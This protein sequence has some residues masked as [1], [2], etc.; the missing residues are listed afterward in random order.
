M[1]SCWRRARVGF[2]LVVACAWPALA[3]AQGAGDLD[4]A[5]AAAERREFGTALALYERLLDLE[6]D[7]ADLWIEAARVSGYADRNAEAAA[8]YRRALEIAPARRTDLLLS[9]AWQTLWA[10]DAAAA[11]SLFDE[12][13]CT[14]A[15]RAEAFDGL[16]QARDALDD[17]EGSIAAWRASLVL[18]PAQ[19]PVE[20][21]LARALMWQGRHG[22]ADA[23]LANA[24][25]RDD[26]DRGTAWL[27][28]QGWNLAG[29]HHDATLEFERLGGPTN[30]DERLDVARAWA[31]SGFDERA[32]AL[33]ADTDDQEAR[34][35][36][37]YRVRR[38]TRPFAD[39]SFERSTDA[40]DLDTTNAIAGFGWRP[41][42]GA[43]AG[44][45][46]RRVE[47]ESPD[48]RA[49]GRELRASWRQ[50]FGEPGGAGG[51]WWPSFA[52]RASQWDG[53]SPWTGDARIA[54]VPRDGWRIDAEAARALVET[55]KAIAERVTVDVLSL[56]VDH[57]PDPR[58]SLALALAAFRFDDG[59]RRERVYGRA[60]WR[61]PVTVRWR[62]GVE[63]MAF[64]SSRPTSAAV[65][66]RGYWNPASYREVRLFTAIDG[67]WRPWDVAA[68]FALGTSR[69]VD[70]DD[71]ESRGK[72]N[73]GE[74]AVGRDLGAMA[75][76]R[77]VVGGSGSG[78]GL[79]GGGSGYW[80]RYAGLS[81]QAWF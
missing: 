45:A 29:R 28:V 26:T 34:W 33:L 31:W 56:G 27:R 24:L 13:T 59:N 70:G 54:W 21:R 52:L 51:I 9:L 39:A 16:G 60:D 65:P 4:R 11:S 22:E 48:G 19:P 36:R 71:V 40:D 23:L 79:T 12:A 14:A 6:P 46:L 72:P 32:L 30:A 25:E 77:A 49:A 20:R 35:W 10:G 2:A 76:V 74:L 64:D 47:L 75:R 53:W 1:R 69:E 50:R 78:F 73:L 42:P 67:E 37:D 7:D 66:D 81:L 58:A 57:R 5:R 43:T 18:R 3:P 80:R 68:R 38:E 61:L 44:L 8:R 15:D 55:P 62:I 63:A 41:R 17:A